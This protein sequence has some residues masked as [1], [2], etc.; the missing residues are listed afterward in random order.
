MFSISPF[1]IDYQPK[2]YSLFDDDY[3]PFSRNRYVEQ[4]APTFGRSFSFRRPSAYQHC[5]ASSFYQPKPERPVE[6]D[7]EMNDPFLDLFGLRGL[8][9]QAKRK[10]SNVEQPVREKSV[11]KPKETLRQVKEPCLES[12]SSKKLKSAEEK[13]LDS[14]RFDTDSEIEFRFSNYKCNDPAGVN[15]SITKENY[16]ELRTAD[17]YTWKLKLSDNVGDL[18]KA[19]CTL[20]NGVLSLKLPKRVLERQQSGE[21]GESQ[22]ETKDEQKIEEKKVEEIDPDAPIVEDIIEEMD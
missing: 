11:C 3:Y 14:Q 9:S 2:S 4:P 1:I 13:V 5:P 20:R 22:K 6:S 12:K 10:E 18:Q 17:G 7:D 19:S 8:R 15:V 21:G 16:I